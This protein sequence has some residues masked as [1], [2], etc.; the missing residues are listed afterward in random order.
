MKFSPL[1][2]LSGVLEKLNTFLESR[3][4]KQKNLIVGAF[5]IFVLLADFFLLVQPVILVFTGTIP[6]LVVQKQKLS[7]LRED[8]KNAPDI[9]KQWE[10]TRQKLAETEK[11]FIPK[12]EIPS[13]LESLS[14]L[15]QESRV[16]I[17]T[18]KPLEPSDAGSGLLKIPIYI[19]AVAGAH[20][21]GK[22]LAFL[23]GGN[24]FFKVIDLRIAANAS[25]DHRHAI[26]LSIEAYAKVK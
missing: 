21:L 6:E 13:L 12:G 25:D 7:D 17:V 15:A 26:E 2:F 10:D 1:I 18:L 23:E 19:S 4:E 16:K 3:E 9:E 24:T 11:Q 20:D 5:F 22:F 14:K 8:I